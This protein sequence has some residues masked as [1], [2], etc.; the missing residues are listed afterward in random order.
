MATQLKAG[1]G[2]LITPPA[3]GSLRARRG[4]LIAP[5]EIAGNTLYSILA[6]GRGMFL[7]RHGRVP[8]E[9]KITAGEVYRMG[10][11]PERLVK[12]GRLQRIEVVQ[13]E[14]IKVMEEGG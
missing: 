8:D 9:T 4:K 10:Y 11:L 3:P 14:E 12:S 7:S 2:E 6:R 1:T 13:E 5:P